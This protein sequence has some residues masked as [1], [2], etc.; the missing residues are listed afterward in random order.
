[1]AKQVLLNVRAFVGPADLT[2]QSN[3]IEL[4]DSMDEKKATTYGSGG[5]EELLAGLETV[6]IGAEGLWDAGD[7]GKIDDEM[8]AN[9]R[10]IEAWTIG[11]ETADAS[12][13]AY[14]T[15]ALRLDSKLFGQ[16]GE[17]FPW[18]LT[19]GG[20]WPLVRGQ[21]TQ[22]PGT[23]IVADGNGTGLNLG[24]TSATQRVYASLHVLSVAGTLAPTIACTIQSAS[25]NAFSSPTTRLTFTTVS[26]VGGQITR[27][28]LGANAHTWY[29]AVF[30]VT[31]NGGVGMSF[32]AVAAIGIA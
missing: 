24:A 30:D 28:A 26:A 12:A 18:T 2:G 29:R 19:A 13:Y 11:P 27:T 31:D 21:I 1:M 10:V 7:P 5:A 15:Q 17:V 4:V 6:A 22:P 3:K 9:R 25:S 23:A 32:L 20:S 16:V 8:W 14:L